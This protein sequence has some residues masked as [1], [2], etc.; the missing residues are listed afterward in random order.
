MWNEF[1]ETCDNLCEAFRDFYDAVS[2]SFCTL[3]YRDY[4]NK[5]LPKKHYGKRRKYRHGTA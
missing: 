4:V 1:F 2:A 5:V 3:S